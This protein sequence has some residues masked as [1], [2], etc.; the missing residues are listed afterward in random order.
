MSG[1]YCNLEGG[2]NA[3]KSCLQTSIK[4]R[5]KKK[6]DLPA[7]SLASILLLSIN[8]ILL[9]VTQ[10]LLPLHPVVP[11][12]SFSFER[13]SGTPGFLVFFYSGSPSILPA[14]FISFMDSLQRTNYH[15][16]LSFFRISLRSLPR[17]HFLV[18]AL[19]TLNPFLGSS[20]CHYHRNAHPSSSLKRHP[21]SRNQESAIPFI[22]VDE[23]NIMTQARA[24]FVLV[25]L[26]PSTPAQQLTLLASRPNFLSI[27]MVSL[28][29]TEMSFSQ[30]TRS[31]F[32]SLV[33][34][35]KPAS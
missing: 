26:S 33:P 31:S 22:L 32:R 16:L 19:P 23:S 10:L 35:Q 24:F 9:P 7:I 12:S 8:K 11:G 20:H 18:S 6:K 13:S 17:Q 29:F 1:P 5:K 27:W 3:P 14:S 15:P 25:F 21:P 28:S 34:V 2:G 30:L 4:K